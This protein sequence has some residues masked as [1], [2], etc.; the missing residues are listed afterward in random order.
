VSPEVRWISD[1]TELAGLAAPWDGLAYADP[2]PFSLHAWY[3]AWWDGYGGDR[4][5]RVCTV[6]DGPQLVGVLPLCAQNGRLEA[7]ANEET[8][9]VRPLARDAEALRLLADAAARERYDLMEIRRLPEGDEGIDALTAAARSARRLSIVE[10]DITSPIVDTTGTLDDYRQATRSKWHKNLRRLYRK[11]ERDH[12]AQLHLVEAPADLESEVTQGF[13]VESSG[14]K[15][16]AGSAILS[17][18]ES[19]AYYRSLARRFHDRGELR[20][21]TIR[22][23]GRMIAWD[24]G[25]LRA[26]RLYSPKSGYLEEFR[27]FGPGLVLELA[28]IER[29]FEL[30]IDAHELLGAD[31]DYK[32]RFSTSER[33][34]RYFRAY[35]RRPA[36]AL[37]YAWRRFVPRRVREARATRREAR[38]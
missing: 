11:L 16:E 17:R 25:I 6:W 35:P 4:E 7:M 36:Q 23:D 37:R 9:L 10:P 14:W 13:E 8:C 21:S 38:A 20:V 30:G 34:H 26:N 22:V 15:R 12:G 28:T 29:C 18:P 27:Q 32:L 19:E 24:L 3:S 2:T 31:E 33:R 5:L 1:P